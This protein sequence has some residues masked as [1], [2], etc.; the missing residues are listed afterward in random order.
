MKLNISLGCGLDGRSLQRLCVAACVCLALGV[1]GQPEVANRVAAAKELR[2]QLQA[3]LS[4]ARAE[5]GQLRVTLAGDDRLHPGATAAEAE[6]HT[7]LTEM[8]VRVYQEHI[9]QVAGLEEAWRQQADLDNT[10]RGWT[11]FAQPAPYSLLLV[12]ELRDAAQSLE[13]KISASE[14]TLKLQALVALDMEAG[15]K[16]S[17]ARLRLLSEQLEAAKDVSPLARLTWQRTLEQLRN[18]RFVASLALSE[19]RRRR[20]EAELAQDRQRHAFIGRQLTLARQHLRFS[21]EDLEQVLAR[22]D[23]ERRAVEEELAEAEVTFEG[24]QRELAAAR[25][26]LRQALQNSAGELAIKTGV[27]AEASRLQALVELRSAQVETGSQRRAVLRRLVELVISERG[28]W[29]IRFSA[30]HAKRLAELKEGYLKLEKLVRL[31]HSVEP[32]FRQ[33]IELAANRVADQR[34]RMQNPPGMQA[35]AASAQEV[36]DCY[37]QQEVLANRALRSFERLQ[38]LALRWQ[39]SLDED[40]QQLPFAARIK[41]VVVG[42]SSAA[43][44]FWNFELFAALDTIAVDGQTVTGRR[45]VTVGKVCMAIL[46]LVVGYWLALLISRLLERA[47]VKYFKLDPNRAS[48]LRRGVRVV[49]LA[50]LVVFSLVSVKIPLTIFA[51]LGG[52]LAIGLGFGTQNL[53]KNFISG[54][55]ILFERPFRIGD[56]LDV[57]G[58]RGVVVSIGI[59]SSVI[60]LFDGT[61]TLIP[62]SALLENNLTN[63]TYTD[64]KVRFSISVGVAYGSDTRRVA[65]V[66]AEEAERHGLV[67]KE[68]APQVLFKDFGDSAMVFEL[69]YWVD[70]IKNDSVQIGSDLRHMVAGAF[71]QNGIALAFPQRD[72]HLDTARP[73]RVRLERA[74]PPGVRREGQSQD[75]VNRAPSA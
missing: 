1:A 68:P 40:R 51:F 30:F 46:I 39:E 54:L 43:V 52:A 59:R 66:L 61:E 21:E 41:D 12:D 4:D 22:L 38:R 71:A 23:A 37:L 44:K 72:V 67:Q 3:R 63:W 70:V 8:L 74:A 28:L 53:L 64:R 62:N 2:A 58:S 7:L 18:R 20:F 75:E 25:E 73:L 11:G 14:A 6:E 60:R 36:L 48:L 42:F 17:D 33:Q 65:Q 45:S 16:E 24:R 13:A 34:N 10:I 5:L 69:R 49:L 19:T 55:I 15:L 27:N 26:G 31:L 32:Y 29:Q 35:D 9:D 56:V 57:G 50:W 47:S